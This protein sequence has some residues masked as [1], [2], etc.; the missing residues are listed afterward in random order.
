[1]FSFFRKLFS[2]PK[3]IYR[4]E[5]QPIDRGA[6]GLEIPSNI[7]ADKYREAVDFID[8]MEIQ[9]AF[10]IYVDL[11]HFESDP[12][13]AWVGLGTC[14]SQMNNIEKAADCYSQALVFQPQN[15]MAMMGLA[16]CAFKQKKY[17]VALSHYFSIQ[18]FKP[19]AI[20]VYW[21]MAVCYDALNQLSE[22][23]SA[24]KKFIAAMPTS[25]YRPLMESILN[26]SH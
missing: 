23:Q 25:R 9:S 3:S 26:K 10:A 20:D 16:S 18:K 11:I 17:S 1:M 22:A 7:Y 5:L 12:S 15:Y 6:I 8:K 2:A 19:D 13:W 4:Q 24:A 21:G 14:N